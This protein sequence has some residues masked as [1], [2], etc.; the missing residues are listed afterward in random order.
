MIRLETS[1]LENQPEYRQSVVM[2]GQ[3]ARRAFGSVPQDNANP[4]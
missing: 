1:L 3:R 2:N 4:P